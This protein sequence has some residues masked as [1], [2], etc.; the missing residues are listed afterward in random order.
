MKESEDSEQ[1]KTVEADLVGTAT[2][3]KRKAQLDYINEYINRDCKMGLFSDLTEAKN[4]SKIKIKAKILR[5]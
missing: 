1:K 3:I 4:F 2:E 5:Q